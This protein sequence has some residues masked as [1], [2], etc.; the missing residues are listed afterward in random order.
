[1]LA[2]VGAKCLIYQSSMCG[3]GHLI[4][5]SWHFNL[6][7]HTYEYHVAISSNIP[8]YEITRVKDNFL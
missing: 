6:E 2:Q 1:M 7:K 4:C 3:K 8:K 5:V